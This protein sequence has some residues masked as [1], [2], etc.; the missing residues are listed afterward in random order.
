MSNIGYF[1]DGMH[2]ITALA[3]LNTAKIYSNVLNN[4]QLGDGQSCTNLLENLSL[5]LF[6]ELQDLRDIADNKT[7]LCEFYYFKKIY[8]VDIY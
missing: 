5:L 1:D 7:Y 6:W 8:C 4:V 2:L 3:P